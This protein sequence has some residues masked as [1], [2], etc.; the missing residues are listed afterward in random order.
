MPRRCWSI[1][2]G[3]GSTGW[4]KSLLTGP[5]VTMNGPLEVQAGFGTSLKVTNAGSGMI[6]RSSALDPISWG[7]ALNLTAVP[8]AGYFFALWG[9]AARGTINPLD[10][11]VTN[12]N[13]TVAALFLPLE[14]NQVTLTALVDGFGYIVQLPAANVY[15]NGQTVTLIATPVSG[16]Q[17]LDWSGALSGSQNP[18]SLTLDGSRTVTARFTRHLALSAKATYPCPS[19]FIR[20]WIILVAASPRCAVSRVSKPAGGTTSHALSSSPAC[21]LVLVMLVK[22][23]AQR[24][25]RSALLPNL[26]DAKR[27]QRG[28]GRRFRPLYFRD[29]S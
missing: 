9:N 28:R 1:R 11:I 17:F 8:E 18:T 10:F 3:L 27:Q 20:G 25:D 21:G 6:I 14:T 22:T 19:V 4:L 24:R 23:A 26:K 13:P 29:E 2:P 15:T 7:G 16:Q 12:A 5:A